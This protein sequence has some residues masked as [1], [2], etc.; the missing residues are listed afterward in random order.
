MLVWFQ[1]CWAK[2]DI[3]NVIDQRVDQHILIRE[4]IQQFQEIF[5]LI[6]CNIVIEHYLNNPKGIF[7]LNPPKDALILQHQ[8]YDFRVILEILM[9]EIVRRNGVAWPRRTD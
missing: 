8:P 6:L 4:N 2:L 9:I 5:I 7:V 1:L 3:F